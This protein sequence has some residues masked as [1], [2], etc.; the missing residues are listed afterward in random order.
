MSTSIALNTADEFLGMPEDG[1]CYELVRGEVI[2]M[3][4]AGALHGFVAMRVAAA[5]DRFVREKKLGVVCVAEAGFRLASQPD[6]V[7]VPD[8]SFVSARRIQPDGIPVGFW[9]F[10]TDLAVEVISPRDTYSEV[11]AKAADYL[12]AGT[13]RVWALD[14]KTQT[15]SVFAPSSPVRVLRV[16]DVLEGEEE[17]AGLSIPLAEVFAR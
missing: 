7:R 13:R 9:P 16:D 6:T 12:A 8:V 11:L 4:P 5:L 14:P 10:P 2:R 15:V 3:T 1:F 17:L